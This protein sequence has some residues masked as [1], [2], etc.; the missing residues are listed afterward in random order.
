MVALGR[1]ASMVWAATGVGS[2]GVGLIT[3]L[4]EWYLVD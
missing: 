2:S 1:A 4:V 3:V